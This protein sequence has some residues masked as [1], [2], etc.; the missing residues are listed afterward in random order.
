MRVQLLNSSE[1]NTEC[2]AQSIVGAVVVV[3]NLIWFLICF[4]C[5]WCPNPNRIFF[6]SQINRNWMKAVANLRSC[7][8]LFICAWLADD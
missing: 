1:S 7:R 8:V 2:I 3:V 4:D 6:I 5:I